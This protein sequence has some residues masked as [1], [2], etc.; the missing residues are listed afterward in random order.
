MASNETNPNLSLYACPHTISTARFIRENKLY[1]FKE[2]NEN[3]WSLKKYTMAHSLR[4]VNESVE[5]Q[6][7]NNSGVSEALSMVT[8]RGLR[9]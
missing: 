2:I 4:N 1:V 7:Q 6:S 8:E 5:I 9:G 3:K